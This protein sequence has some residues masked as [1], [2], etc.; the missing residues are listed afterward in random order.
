M[1]F[2]DVVLRINLLDEKAREESP[3]ITERGYIS[4]QR[5]SEQVV[6][7]TLVLAIGT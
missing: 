5:Q 1:N 3:T 6:L 7:G 2:A 4:L